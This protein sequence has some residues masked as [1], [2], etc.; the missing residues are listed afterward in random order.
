MNP[1]QFIIVS[2][3]ALVISFS[4]M[5]QEHKAYAQS[6][7]APSLDRPSCSN[8]LDEFHLALGVSS[9]EEVYDALYDGRSLADIADANQ[10]DVQQLIDLQVAQLSEQLDR[11]YESGSLPAHQYEAHK[12]ELRLMIADSV[13]GNL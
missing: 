12:A 2:T 1:K 13:Y 11:R 5:M 4:S 10:R 8:A 7:G 3:M 6:P 9:D